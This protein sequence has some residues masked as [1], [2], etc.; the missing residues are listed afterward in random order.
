[1]KPCSSRKTSMP[2]RL[3]ALP[4]LVAS[5]AALPSES[6]L[7]YTAEESASFA[8]MPMRAPPHNTCWIETAPPSDVRASKP[9][10]AKSQP[11]RSSLRS[12]RSRTRMAMMMGC[13]KWEQASRTFQRPTSPK[14]GW[15]SRYTTRLSVRPSPVACPILPIHSLRKRSSRKAALSSG[16]SSGSELASREPSARIT[17]FIHVWYSSEMRL[18]CRRWPR[19][20]S[21]A[22][23]RRESAVVSVVVVHIALPNS[24]TLAW[25]SVAESNFGRAV[26]AVG[27]NSDPRR[28]V[29]KKGGKSTINDARLKQTRCGAAW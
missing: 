27:E 28:P 4:A 2:T 20:F 24:A 19:S 23:L 5:S 29:E 10:S 9:T 26:L 21:A 1:M 17:A 22:R 16:G 6:V 12:R 11:S 3:A 13:A 18:I 7:A 8:R 25:I 14:R 15:S